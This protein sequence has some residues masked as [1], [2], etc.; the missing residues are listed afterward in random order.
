LP[1]Y[2]ARRPGVAQPNAAAI[3]ANVQKAYAQL[4]AIHAVAT[5]EQTLSDGRGAV[6]SQIDYE[7]AEKPARQ[8][9]RRLKGSRRAHSE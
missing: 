1:C 2:P 7:L 9:P 8:V 5:Q 3:L 4:T 6:S